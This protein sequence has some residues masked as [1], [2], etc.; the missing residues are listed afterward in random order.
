MSRLTLDVFGKRV[1]V[2]R[3]SAG[4]KVWYVGPEGKRRPA[5]D[6]R[7]PASLGDHE[8]AQYIADLCHEWATER[9]PEVRRLD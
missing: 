3:D 2:E 7:V 9:H 1:W 4:W 8:V 5:S 6:I